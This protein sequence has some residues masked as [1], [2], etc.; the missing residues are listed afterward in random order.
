MSGA[1]AGSSP[2]AASISFARSRHVECAG[3]KFPRRADQIA[4]ADIR[5]DAIERFG[6]GSLVLN[7]ATWDAFDVA[8]AIDVEASVVANAD[9]WDQAL[10]FVGRVRQDLL[11]L[12]GHA[13]ESIQDVAVAPCPGFMENVADHGD[14]SARAEVSHDVGYVDCTP[15]AFAFQASTK[16]PEC[17]RRVCLALQSFFHQKRG[18]A[19]NDVGLLLQIEARLPGEGLQQ[20]PTLVERTAGNPKLSALETGHVVDRGRGGHHHRAERARIWIKYQV[21]A[22]R[23][24]AR[25]P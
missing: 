2:N 20:Q 4:A 9:A 23:A 21:V 8:P 15:H 1:A 11:C 16:I 19:I 3:S 10:P 5:Q 14:R 18:C 22:E 13:E 12:T 6:V 7:R 25:D 24:L 17:Q